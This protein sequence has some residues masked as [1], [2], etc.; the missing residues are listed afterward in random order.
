MFRAETVFRIAFM[1]FMVGAILPL[2]IYMITEMRVGELMKLMLGLVFV[3]TALAITVIEL[4]LVNE[5][6]EG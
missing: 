5:T 6:T 1:V 3:A 4:I 2:G